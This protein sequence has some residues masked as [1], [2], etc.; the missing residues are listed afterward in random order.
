MG[1]LNRMIGSEKGDDDLNS[2][3]NKKASWE[4]IPI[5]VGG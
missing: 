2:S 3:L 1:K 5:F 4:D